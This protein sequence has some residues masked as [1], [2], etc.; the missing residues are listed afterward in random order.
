MF[1]HE[2]KVNKSPTKICRGACPANEPDLALNLPFLSNICQGS[3]C[4]GVIDIFYRSLQVI[5]RKKPEHATLGTLWQ[6]F[7]YPYAVGVPLHVG[8]VAYLVRSHCS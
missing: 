8:V 2:R 7:V 4:L 3:R 6:A 1:S 5:S